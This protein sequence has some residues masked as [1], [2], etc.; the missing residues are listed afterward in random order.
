MISS[1]HGCGKT[2]LAKELLLKYSRFKDT[3]RLNP[4]TLRFPSEWKKSVGPRDNVIILLDDIF[5]KCTVDQENLKKWATLF[6][7]I[8][9]CINCNSSSVYVIITVRDNILKQIKDVLTGYD[10]FKNIDAFVI[11]LTLD[12]EDKYKMCRSYLYPE[13]LDLEDKNEMC[14]SHLSSESEI[15]VREILNIPR[16]FAFPLCCA[17][18]IEKDNTNKSI[19]FFSNPLEVILSE[20]R[21]ICMNDIFAIFVLSL[22]LFSPDQYLDLQMTSE[23]S[24]KYLT[25]VADVFDIKNSYKNLLGQIDNKLRVLNDIYI[26]EDNERIYFISDAILGVMIHIVGEKYINYLINKLEFSIL[27]KYTTVTQARHNE[28][29]I[30]PRNFDTLTD[31]YL[32][33]LK[34]GLVKDIVRSEAME[35]ANFVTAFVLKLKRFRQYIKWQGR[36]KCVQSILYLA[37]MHKPP[38]QTLISIIMKH[39]PKIKMGKGLKQKYKKWFRKEVFFVL[40]CH[41]KRSDDHLMVLLSTFFETLPNEILY[42]CAK[43]SDNTIY[44]YFLNSYPWSTVCKI[45]ARIKR[46]FANRQQTTNDDFA[47]QQLRADDGISN[48]SSNAI[49]PSMLF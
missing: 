21:N 49:F 43:C 11:N 31:R 32:V 10:L 30:T 22:I 14:I 2:F 9:T 41:L 4:V 48:F 26:L 44:E 15:F 3:F 40:K 13:S 23:T 39:G 1:G 16:L 36:E 46:K 27:L 25:E 47:D 28:F 33:E 35:D 19:D 7:D 12:Y 37:V 24:K 8:H 20:F 18:Y 34:N 29:V 5:G 38:K 17:K 42:V 45:K 6:T